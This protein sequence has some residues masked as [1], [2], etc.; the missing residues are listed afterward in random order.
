MAGTKGN[1]GSNQDGPTRGKK[2][3]QALT[4]GFALGLMTLV[5]AC[6]PQKQ[7]LEMNEH[8]NQGIRNGEAV[9]EADLEAQS[10]V[11]LYFRPPGEDR[12]V[13]FCSASL[14]GEKTL[15]T[16]A[17][18]LLGLSEGLMK[19]I[20]EILPYVQ[21]GFGLK[22]AESLDDE[23][24]QMIAVSKALVH[25]DFSMD[26]VI[27]VSPTTPIPDLALL[28]LAKPA[29]KGFK[30]VSLLRDARQI[31]AG[32]KLSLAG[33]GLTDIQPAPTSASELRKV[34]VEVREPNFNPT[35]FS[36][37][38]VN[39]RGSCSGDSG[40]PAYLKNSRGQLL[41]AGVTSFGDRACNRMGVYT[42]VPA[43]LTWIETGLENFEIP[44]AT[45]LVASLSSHVRTL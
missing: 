45:D 19:E 21:V 31:T 34:Q 12:L 3:G 22:V 14:V 16:A 2:W 42:S 24:I 43:M 18:C 32:V 36:Y 29:P 44:N 23:N 4:S 7:L 35:Q 1:T 33:Y 8:E 13:S 9:L 17:H 10:T 5:S 37:E 27:K 26:S 30:R 15:L 6:G 39:G 38:I 25:P 11:A 40:G 41:L 20:P 28:Q